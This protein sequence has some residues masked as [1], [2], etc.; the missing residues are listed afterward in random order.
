MAASREVGLSTTFSNFNTE[1]DS[2]KKELLFSKNQI[3][4]LKDDLVHRH[5]T[6]QQFTAYL[7]E[8]QKAL[9]KLSAMNELLRIKFH[10]NT[11]Q[12]DSL[13]SKLQGIFIQLNSL[14]STDE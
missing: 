9:G 3:T 11:T 1:I 7:K 12:F 10:Q 2:I 6:K 4:S 13:E 8:E 14:Q 5:L